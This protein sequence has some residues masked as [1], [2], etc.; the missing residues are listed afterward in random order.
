MADY[1]DTTVEGTAY[2]RCPQFIGWNPYGG[3]PSISFAEEQ[4]INLTGG[5]TI[6]QPASGFT[7]MLTPETAT[8]EIPILDPT[9]GLPTGTSVTF[10]QVYGIMYSVYIQLAK[11]RDEA[12]AAP[13]PAPAPTPEPA[14]APAA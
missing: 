8:N 5:Q 14:P 7:A 11:E 3:T 9:T 12:A 4:V 10:A 6:R 2:V 1:K 13:A